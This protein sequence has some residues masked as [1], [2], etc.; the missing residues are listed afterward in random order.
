[1]YFFQ[2]FITLLPKYYQWNIQQTFSMD[3][4]LTRNCSLCL[5]DSGVNSADMGMISPFLIMIALKIHTHRGRPTQ[6]HPKMINT[7]K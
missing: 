6:V 3:L 7:E 2:L 4:I 1:M 5:S